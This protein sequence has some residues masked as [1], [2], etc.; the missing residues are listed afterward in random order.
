MSFKKNAKG[1]FSNLSDKLGKIKVTKSGQNL[2]FFDAIGS[3]GQL[4]ITQAE[5]GKKLI[6]IG[7]GASASIASHM[8]T[9]FWKNG[10]MRAVAFNDAAL[11][12]CL[13]NDC[14]YENVFGKSI[15][16]FAD[17]G[18]I[19]FAISSSGKSENILNGVRAARN[20]GAK[21]V[22][23]SGFNSE[24]PLRQM[25][26]INFYVPD[27]GYGA[28]EILHLATCHCILDVIIMEKVDVTH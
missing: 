17:E 6:F 24:N 14:G 22:T 27:G 20:Q 25:G 5:T 3:V 23:L 28:V 15:D 26:D 13:S 21:V 2:G 19:L 11:L 4:A 1:Y 10:G 8:S 9:D 16:M 12:T 7:N 18:D